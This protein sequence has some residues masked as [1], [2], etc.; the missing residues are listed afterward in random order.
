M[1]H[2]II[3]YNTLGTQE[4]RVVAAYEVDA[5]DVRNALNTAAR[6]AV[7]WNKTEKR[8]NMVVNFV[9]ANGMVRTI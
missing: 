2:Q 5:D 9:N 8:T 7:A 1:T 4:S 3:A 6:Q